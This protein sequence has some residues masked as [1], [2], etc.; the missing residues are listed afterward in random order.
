MFSCFFKWGKN[1]FHLSHRKVSRQKS[2]GFQS[3]Q[4]AATQTG[5]A[6]TQT[7]N[8]A[9]QTDDAATQT[10]KATVAEMASQTDDVT[11]TSVAKKSGRM[12]DSLVQ[13][14]LIK[15]LFSGT[16]RPV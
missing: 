2:S 4:N 1:K 12:F 16:Q 3:P 5:D 6:T 14:T 7:D 9:T 8:A 11:V 10:D 15:A 13:I